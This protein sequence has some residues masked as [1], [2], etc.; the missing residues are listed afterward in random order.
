MKLQSINY[1]SP[2]LTEGSFINVFIEETSFQLKRQ[3]NY[4]RIE[5]DMYYIKDNQVIKLDTYPLAFQG[6]NTDEY[7][8]NRKATFRF[9]DDTE[10]EEPRGLIAYITENQGAYP[11]NYEMI[12]WGYPSYE[13]ALN[14]LDGGSFDVPEIQPAND[15]VKLWLLNTIIMKNE[16]IVNQFQFI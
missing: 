6:M 15:F 7:T 3:E 5:F 13:D 12:D 2:I 11:E 10:E 9:L 16:H 8:T 4:L 14:Y 1:T